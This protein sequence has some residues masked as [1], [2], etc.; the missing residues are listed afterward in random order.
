[1]QRSSPKYWAIKKIIM[2]YRAKVV[3]A[4]AQ[5]KKHNKTEHEYLMQ[6]RDLDEETL[7]SIL[8]VIGDE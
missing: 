8:V 7:R 5:V 4:F 2:S 6:I 3:G 1:M